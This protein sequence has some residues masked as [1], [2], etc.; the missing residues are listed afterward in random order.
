M[1]VGFL[2]FFNI[3]LKYRKFGNLLDRR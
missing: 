1:V 3:F 2:F